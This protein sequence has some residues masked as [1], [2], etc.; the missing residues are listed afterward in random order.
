VE[1]DE[2]RLAALLAESAVPTLAERLAL[3]AGGSLA[4]GL[5]A[6]AAEVA[7]KLGVTDAATSP[8]EAAAQGGG[9]IDTNGQWSHR[10]Q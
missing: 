6:A 2:R 5:A 3:P 7:E 10:H 4:R 1:V 8:E 9:G